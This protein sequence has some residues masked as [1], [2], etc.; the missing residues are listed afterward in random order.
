ME[1]SAAWSRIYAI[2]STLGKSS[3]KGTSTGKA[4]IDLGCLSDV[5][6]GVTHLQ[7]VSREIGAVALDMGNSASRREES[8]YLTQIVN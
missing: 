6:T 7:S 2:V 3:D 4:I 1:K 5:E 8:R